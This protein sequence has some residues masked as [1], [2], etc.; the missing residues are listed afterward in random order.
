MLGLEAG[1]VVGFVMKT[2]AIAFGIFM[3]LLIIQRMKKNK[4]DTN[5]D[6]P[7]GPEQ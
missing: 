1:D 7:G 2:V 3:A 4:L 6:N 5:N